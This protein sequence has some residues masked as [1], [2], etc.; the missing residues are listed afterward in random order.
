[1]NASRDQGSDLPWPLST[2]V[3][4]FPSQKFSG[5]DLITGQQPPSFLPLTPDATISSRR[6]DRTPVRNNI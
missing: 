2:A 4:A 1:M 3:L 6:N 5:K